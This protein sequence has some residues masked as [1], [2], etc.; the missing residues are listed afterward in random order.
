MHPQ[1]GYRTTTPAALAPRGVLVNVPKWSAGRGCFRRVG[2]A[3]T[4]KP[5][6]AGSFNESVQTTSVPEVHDKFVAKLLQRCVADD[7]TEELDELRKT[8]LGVLPSLYMPT[9]RNED[10][11]FTD[12]TPILKSDIQA[13]P[14]PKPKIDLEG[15]DLSE[16]ADNKV[17]IVD[18]VADWEASSLNLPEGAYVGN[19]EGAP[20]SSGLL[21]SLSEER[22][23][24][25]SVLNGAIATDAIVIFIKSGV[26][27]EKPI[28]L[29]YHSSG[30]PSG[31]PVSAPRVLVFCGEAS[32]VEIVEEYRS[33]SDDSSTHLVL[34]ICEIIAGTNS[35]IVH[36]YAQLEGG[37]AMHMKGT[38]VSQEAGSKYELIEARV[39]GALT[40]HDVG[41]EQ[42]GAET[43]TAMSHF[44]LCGEEQLHDLHSRLELNHP[45]GLADQLHKCIVTHSSGRGVFDGNVKVNQLAQKTDA[46]QL[47]RNLLIVPKATVNVKPNLQII[48]DDVKC[49]HGCAVSDLSEEE[50]FYF[51]ARGVDVETARRALVYSFGAEVIQK[52]GHKGL[53]KRIQS[54]VESTLES[55]GMS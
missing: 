27:V 51:R 44:L 7:G 36:R 38:L 54:A 46:G 28:H 50:I 45:R 37:K 42:E 39:G 10:Y 26:E 1:V 19:P 18:G 34:S 55:A 32:S 3:R 40:R 9:T 23:G 29:L 53:I 21:G 12:I 35:R 17:V 49:T 5:I 47:S 31:V 25:F 43:E 16:D 41:I 13:P 2:G 30:S 22:G 11:R 14:S 4:L 6:G 48:A 15:T 52:F 24:P 20:G 8:C 33:Q